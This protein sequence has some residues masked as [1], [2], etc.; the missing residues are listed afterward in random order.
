M[1]VSLR[2]SLQRL[3]LVHRSHFQLP[4]IPCPADATS[5]WDLV[6][7]LTGVHVLVATHVNHTPRQG[8]PSHCFHMPS[9]HLDK[10]LHLD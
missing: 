5:E 3:G 9:A 4:Y 7:S 8:A 1:L 6:L 2:L 10:S